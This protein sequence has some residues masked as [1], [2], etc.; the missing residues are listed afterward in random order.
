MRSARRTAKEREQPGCRRDVLG[1]QQVRGGKKREQPGL[2]V[3][4]VR[5]AADAKGRQ[6]EK[7]RQS[8]S[9][10]KRCTSLENL[11]KERQENYGDDH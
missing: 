5:E 1:K 3:G 7:N 2:R 10:C 9:L 8:E 6:R 11:M 4:C